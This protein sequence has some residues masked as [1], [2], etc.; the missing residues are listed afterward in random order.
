[1]S[2]LFCLRPYVVDRFLFQYTQQF[3][4]TIKDCKAQ[5]VATICD[6]NRVNQAFFRMFDTQTDCP[7]R[8]KSNIFLLYDYVHLL[9]SVKNNWIT[10]KTQQIIFTLS[11]GN[12]VAK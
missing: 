4:F 9:E 2:A 7:W 10:E 12:H 6:G 5:V 3:L 1:M 8:T 11:G